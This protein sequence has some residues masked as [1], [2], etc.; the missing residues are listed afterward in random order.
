MRSTLSL[1]LPMPGSAKASVN[2]YAG[3]GRVP[4]HTRE[5]FTLLVQASSVNNRKVRDIARDVMVS[6]DGGLAGESVPLRR[7]G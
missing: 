5:A 3:L 7:F 1:P 4:A 6:A 2:L